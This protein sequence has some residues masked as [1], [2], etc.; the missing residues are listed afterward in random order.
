MKRKLLLAAAGIAVGLTLAGPHAAEVAAS[1][2]EVRPLLIG[3]RVPAA[4]IRGADGT[5]VRLDELLAAQP[6][7]VVLYRGGW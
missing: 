2:T 4:E 1:Q 5:V 3:A 7:I 6:T